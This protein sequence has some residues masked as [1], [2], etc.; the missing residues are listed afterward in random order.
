LERKCFATRSRFAFYDYL[1]AVFELY[2]QLR[3]TKQV[4]KVATAIAKLFGFRN[5]KRAHAIRVIIDATS[6]ADLKTRSRWARALR[7][8][9]RERKGTLRSH[10]RNLSTACP[11]GRLRRFLEPLA[12][13]LPFYGRLFDFELRG[14]SPTSA[15]IDLG[16][17][18]LALQKGRTQPADDGRHFG[19]VVDDKEAVRKALANVGIKPL[20]GRFL[21]FLDPWGNRI[22]IVA[23]DNV[24]FSK[25]PNVLRSMRLAHLSKN[26]TAIK[27]FPTRAWRRTD[28]ATRGTMSG[29]TLHPAQSAAC[30][31]A[32]P[33]VGSL[34]ELI[35]ERGRRIIQII[36]RMALTMIINPSHQYFSV[37]SSGHVT[38]G[39]GSVVIECGYKTKNPGRSGCC[40]RIVIATTFYPGTT[41]DI[42]L[43]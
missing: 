11:P 7:Y 32:A 8:A 13:L 39:L 21:D 9:W 36:E 42:P 25:T 15:F 41:R 30:P 6:T 2:V 4:K 33:S 24:Q 12:V 17:Q 1:A 18:F 19:L 37:F 14:K 40:K 10:G 5:R 38:L 26:A 27:S 34:S 22:E 28:Q 20:P 43:S 16:D 31:V 29:S 3:R 23:Y 35:D